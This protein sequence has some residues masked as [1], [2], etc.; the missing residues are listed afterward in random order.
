MEYS[1]SK[2][3]KYSKS[4]YVKYEINKKTFSYSKRSRKKY[5]N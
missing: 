2:Y 3:S 4:K 1:K 5:Y